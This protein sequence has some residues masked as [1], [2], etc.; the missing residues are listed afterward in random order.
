M[1]DEPTLP[2]ATGGEQSAPLTPTPDEEFDNAIIRR[3]LNYSKKLSAVAKIAG[4]KGI[5]SIGGKPYFN[6]GGC[7][8]IADVMGVSWGQWSERRENYEDGHFEYFFEAD[9]SYA[10]RMIHASGSRCSRDD[11]YSTAHGKDIPPSEIDAG[12]VR[13]AALS[14]LLHNGV[15][16]LLGLK[17]LTWEELQR[18][19]ITDEGRSS[20]DYGGQEM[21]PDALD[22]KTLVSKLLKEMS[23][24]DKEVAKHY[25]QRATTW[26]KPDGTEVSGKVDLNKVSE[27]QMGVCLRKLREIEK[28]LAECGEGEVGEE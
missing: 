16:N 23:G 15:S 18:A 22:E 21:R 20:V 3:A 14:N 17:N 24:G 12:D 1:L 5:D 19:G 26:T 11:F 6:S 4:R 25:L 13:K 8:R 2:V 10:N 28:E 7:S 27:K 9:F